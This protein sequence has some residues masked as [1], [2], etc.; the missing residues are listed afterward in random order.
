MPSFKIV[1]IPQDASQPIQER[2]ITYTEDTKVSCLMDVARDHF[3]TVKPKNAEEDRKVYAEQ[4][5]AQ[6]KAKGFK[7]PEGDTS[8]IMDKLMDVQMI[9]TVAVQLNHPDVDNVAVTVYV[10]DRA[11]AKGSEMNVRAT[12]FCMSA[13]WQQGILGDAFVARARDDNNDLFERMNFTMADLDSSAPWF[14]GA[15]K[16]N[17]RRTQPSADP[18]SGGATVQQVEKQPLSKYASMSGEERVV[19]AEKFKTAGNEHFK[20]GNLDAA[21]TAYAEALERLVNLRTPPTALEMRIA[22]HNNTALCLF[23]QERWEDASSH[24]TKAIALDPDNVKALFRRGASK[25]QQGRLQDALRD[26][27]RALALDPQAKYVRKL[28]KTVK[29]Q[30]EDREKKKGGAF[31]AGGI[32]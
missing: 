25:H 15:L 26:L 22:L 18:T 5:L 13:G 4:V 2:E 3:R 19:E 6:A 1:F 8:G 14:Q 23:K 29:K 27:R 7:L 16:L 20:T 32:F 9:D 24:A 11:V 17:S 28:L 21:C 12:Q 30:H 31:K 10:D